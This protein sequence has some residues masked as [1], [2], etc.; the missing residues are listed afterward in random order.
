MG[1]APSTGLGA[2]STALEVAVAHFA[3]AHSAAGSSSSSSSSSPTT[4]NPRTF[5]DDRTAVITG[6]SAGIGLE[7]ARALAWAGCRVVIGCR[8][9]PEVVAARLTAPS[10][11]PAEGAF[12]RA[13]PLLAGAADSE[14]AAGVLS[15]SDVSRL[16]VVHP[17]DLASLPSVAAFAAAVQAE[18]RIDYLVRTRWHEGGMGAAHPR[19]HALAGWPQC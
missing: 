6:G 9:A 11:R 15:P 14:A 5:L 1:A 19:R 8:T 7:M 16:V 17:L 13:F 4:T 2:K 18:P 12:D 3:A 10:G